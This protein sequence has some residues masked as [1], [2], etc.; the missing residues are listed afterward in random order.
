M[1]SAGGAIEYEV[2]VAEVDDMLGDVVVAV[3]LDSVV[4]LEDF[5]EEV[6]SVVKDVIK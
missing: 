3:K 2:V 6:F 4:K 5:V 1:L